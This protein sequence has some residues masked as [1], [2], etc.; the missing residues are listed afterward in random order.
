M[1]SSPSARK[2]VKW[3]SEQLF[4]MD[5]KVFFKASLL[6]DFEPRNY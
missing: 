3:I 4:K 1:K 2:S 6:A 5:F